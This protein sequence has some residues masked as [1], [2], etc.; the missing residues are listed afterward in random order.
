MKN[1]NDL[2]PK[3]AIHCPTPE[4]AKKIIELNGETCFIDYEPAVNTYFCYIPKEKVYFT[5]A[6]AIQD[7]YTIHQAFEFLPSGEDGTEEIPKPIGDFIIENAKAVEG[8]DGAYY[9][10]SEVC[11]LVKSM[12]KQPMTFDPEPLTEDQKFF[13]E[14]VVRLCNKAIDLEQSDWP[15][16][17]IEMAKDL[18]TAVKQH[19][20]G[21][22]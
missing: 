12:Q 19:E 17:T 9:H 3:D 20:N 6:D 7:G 11:K 5:Y 4:L 22:V 15:N 14:L 8:L 21:K 18:F 10:Y 16:L 1:I 2:G 13:R